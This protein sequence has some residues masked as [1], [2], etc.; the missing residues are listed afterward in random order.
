MDYGLDPRVRMAHFSAVVFSRRAVSAY[1]ALLTALLSIGLADWATA[2]VSYDTIDELYEQDFNGLPTNAPGNATIESGTVTPP[3][4]LYTEGWQDDVDPTTTAEDDISI[5]GWNLYHVDVTTPEGGF[6]GRQRMRFGPGNS[7]TG[8]FYGFAAGANGAASAANSEKALGTLPSNSIADSPPAMPDPTVNN[9]Y[10][11]FMALRL[12]ND[13]GQTLNEFTL[14]YDG[15]QWRDGGSNGGDPVPAGPQS[16]NFSWRVN[17]TNIHQIAGFVDVP[18]LSFSSPVFTNIASGA[19]VNG[20]TDGL[21]HI[22]AFTVTGIDWGPGED[23]WLRWGDANSPGADHGLAIDNV[24]FSAGVG[25]EEPPFAGDHNED[26][27]V[28]AAD[29]VAWSK[30]PSMFDP[31]GYEDFYENFAEV[32]MLETGGSGTVPEPSGVVLAGFV[33]LWMLLSQRRGACQFARS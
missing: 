10:I 21:D 4:E 19:S 8:A 25:D 24:R 16:L 3:T 29:Y 14:E 28:D 6:N 7:A 13:T 12:T 32:E 9:D 1:A 30:I 17:A 26:G 18:E 15:E 33:A 11:I 2:A 23:L 31:D 5:L 27:T 22:D 20:N